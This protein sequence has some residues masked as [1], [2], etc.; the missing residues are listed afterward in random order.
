M[1]KLIEKI[2]NHSRPVVQ[3]IFIKHIFPENMKTSEVVIA[4]SV[5]KTFRR[6]QQPFIKYMNVM[7]KITYA[8]ISYS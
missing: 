3:K 2:G 7:Y 5:E 8:I 1:T 4:Y 6:F